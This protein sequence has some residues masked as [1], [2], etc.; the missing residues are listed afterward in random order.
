MGTP[1]LQSE[2]ALETYSYDIQY[3]SISGK[4]LKN[5]EHCI[6]LQNLYSS[7]TID[8]VSIVKIKWAGHD[9]FKDEM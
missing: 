7:F 4:Q 2:M 3:P 8:R 5:L 6:M 1:F 9:T